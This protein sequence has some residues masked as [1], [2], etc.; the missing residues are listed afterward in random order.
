MARRLYL[1]KGCATNIKFVEANLCRDSRGKMRSS[2]VRLQELERQSRY[3]SGRKVQMWQSTTTAARTGRRRSRR[4]FEKQQ[5][6]I[7]TST[8]ASQSRPIFQTKP[9][10]SRCSRQW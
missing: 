2:R 4:N 8:R 9:K 6:R 3:G 7:A 10:S 5:K 1:L